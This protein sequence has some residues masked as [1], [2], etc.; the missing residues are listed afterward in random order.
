MH[1]SHSECRSK[2]RFKTIDS[3][4]NWLHSPVSFYSDLRW[5]FLRFSS[6]SSAHSR[7]WWNRPLLIYNFHRIFMFAF[8]VCMCFT[9]SIW[10]SSDWQLKVLQF[11]VYDSSSYDGH[12]ALDLLRGKALASQ[13]CRPSERKQQL[14][15]RFFQSDRFQSIDV[16][17]YE[18]PKIARTFLLSRN[19][20]G[21][22]LKM[23]LAL[24]LMILCF[25]WLA[26]SLYFFRMCFIS[27]I[28][29]FEPRAV[30]CILKVKV[31]FI[32]KKT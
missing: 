10:N 7:W 9:S 13:V 27:F 25:E 24:L 16:D 26:F 29:L 17:W 1:I 28:M 15:G 2:N 23:C 3:P 11:K 31:D 20:V 21:C 6:F 19:C 32:I 14:N 18:C 30:R 22:T 4:A 5:Y 12:R 8:I